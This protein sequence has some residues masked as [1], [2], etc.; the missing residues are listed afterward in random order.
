MQAF[1][2]WIFRQHRYFR[3]TVLVG[4]LAAQLP[5]TLRDLPRLGTTRY[6]D[7]CSK[8]IRS[9]AAEAWNGR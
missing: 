5:G 3:M 4:V 2:K 7:E 6:F 8:G 1:S 9:A